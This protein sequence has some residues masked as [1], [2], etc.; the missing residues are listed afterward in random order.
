MKM[1]QKILRHFYRLLRMK[2]GFFYSFNVELTGVARLRPVEGRV[3]QHLLWISVD[4][5]AFSKGVP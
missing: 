3:M 2:N 5:Y 1:A 4:L